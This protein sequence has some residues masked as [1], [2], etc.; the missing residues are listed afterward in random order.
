MLIIS[1]E[2]VFSWL[3]IEIS[4]CYMLVTAAELHVSALA[5]CPASLTC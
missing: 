4:E 5:M 2:A 3:L 1:K